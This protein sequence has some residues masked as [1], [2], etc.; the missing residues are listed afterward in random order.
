MVR[1]VQHPLLGSIPQLA[2]PLHFDSLDV[3]TPVTA[4][5][6]LGQDTVSILRSYAFDENEI[7]SLLA[8]NVI[9]QHGGSAGAS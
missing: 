5:P 6:L 3:Q 2:L 9:M 7:D 1:T 8:R 4:P